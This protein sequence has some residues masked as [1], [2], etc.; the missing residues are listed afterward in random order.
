[1]ISIVREDVAVYLLA[2]NR[3]LREA[4][5]R[6]LGKMGGIRLVGVSPPSSEALGEIVANEPEV[7]LFDSIGLA[8]G[9]P[10]LLSDLHRSV[11]HLKTILFGMEDD[12]EKFLLAV[13][14]GILGYILKD[15][16][17]RELA[18]AIRM[19]ANDE[20]V[21]P[22]GLCRAL[23]D[24]VARQATGQAP[25][26]RVMQHLRLSRREQQLV[27]LLAEGLTNKEIAGKLN[28]SEQTIKN[29]VRNMLHKGRV[30]DRIEFVELCRD[31]GLCA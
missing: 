5:A 16:S 12:A 6:I 14:G 30:R 19:V 26:V 25:N 22:P 8:L 20:A 10:G 1:M 13:R 2:E 7:L 11:P 23:F 4:L 15:A 3:L 18:S 24:F 17:A 9:E 21:C 29:H 31:H 27:Q 28:L